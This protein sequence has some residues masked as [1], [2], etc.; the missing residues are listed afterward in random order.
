MQADSFMQDWVNCYIDSFFSYLLARF[1]KANVKKKK[2]VIHA[3]IHSLNNP[4]QNKRQ[5]PCEG[6][7]RKKNRRNYTCKITFQTGKEK[8]NKYYF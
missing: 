4:H 5:K 6:R 7:K 1:I 2:K 3:S 8:K